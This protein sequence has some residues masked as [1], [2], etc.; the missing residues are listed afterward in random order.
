MSLLTKLFHY[1]LLTTAKYNID[2]S[3]GLTHSMSV[4][5]FAENIYNCELHHNIELADQKNIITISAVLH[6]MC[7]KKY[8]NETQGIIE[9]AEY[10]EGHVSTEEIEISKKII[11]TMSYS[12]VKKNGFPDLGK[13]QTAYNI[14]R[15]ADLLAAYDFDRCMIYQIQ[16]NN[17]NIEEVYQDALELFQK[18]IFRHKSDGLF[19]TDYAINH[20]EL[21]KFQAMRRIIAWEKILKKKL[22]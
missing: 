4:L 19:I 16:K 18:R 14:V 7:D 12:T 20:S 8:M 1:V 2:E 22:K 5:H 17:Q 6:D 3:H 21:L 15:E 10:L 13:Y 9:M 11:S